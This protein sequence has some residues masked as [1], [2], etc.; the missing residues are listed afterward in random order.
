MFTGHAG[1]QAKDTTRKNRLIRWATTLLTALLLLSGCNARSGG[2]ET[3]AA[4]GDAPLV[5]DL[6][7]LVV[8][9]A[10][11]G[12]PTVGGVPLAEFA[13]ILPAPL[14]SQL[15]FPTTTLATL[16]DANIQH[17]QLSNT[18]H[19]VQ[20]LLNG[21][22]LPTIAWDDESLANATFLLASAGQGNLE[23]MFRVLPMITDVGAGLVLR[24][25][26]PPGAAPL[27]LQP[28]AGASNAALAQEARARFVEGAGSRPALRIP[29]Q[30]EEDGSWRVQGLTDSEWQVLT[31]LPFGGLRLNRDF[32]QDARAA[33]VRTATVR[34]DETGL[35]LAINDE[36]L[37][38]LSWEGGGLLTLV[39]LARTFGL[40]DDLPID[41]ATLDALLD[42]WLPALLAAEITLDVTLPDGNR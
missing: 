14:I 7:A 3:A 33:G 20:L 17:L 24:F 31:G 22:P 8:D 4:A 41:L 10:A 25:P 38:Y 26:T 34:M 27:P 2:G 28:A 13:G 29:V 32:L 5:A 9:Y 6:P 16:A 39:D 35:H 1:R 18:P 37:P 42:A 19:G 23:E 36:A 12:T 21:Q 40:L 11:D 30:Y 15:Q